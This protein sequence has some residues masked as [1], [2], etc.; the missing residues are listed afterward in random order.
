MILQLKAGLEQ[1]GTLGSVFDSAPQ[2]LTP[3]APTPQM[4][5]MPYDPL[6]RPHRQDSRSSKGSYYPSRHWSRQVSL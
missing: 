5:P 2:T 3:T 4:A 6:A 1:T